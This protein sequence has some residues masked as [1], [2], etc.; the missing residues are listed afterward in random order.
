MNI[1]ARDFADKLI[2][3][4]YKTKQ[5][6]KKKKSINSRGKK[7]LNEEGNIIIGFYVA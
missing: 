7:R 5:N 4:I 6:T 1:L 2:I 3:G